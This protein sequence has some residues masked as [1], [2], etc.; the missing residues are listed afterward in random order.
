MLLVAILILVFSKQ[1]VFYSQLRPG[2]HGNLFR[3]YKLCSMTSEENTEERTVTGI[4]KILRKTSIDEL[5]QLI[6]ILRGEMS[7][8][9]P[10]P[11]LPEYLALYSDKHARRH[12]VKPGLTGLAQ[13][14]GR[15]HS[16]W[17]KRL[18]LDVQYVEQM[19]FILDLKIIGKTIFNIT[20]SQG[21]EFEM[22]KF[23]GYNEATTR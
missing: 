19:S 8:V 18:D 20:K 13:I 12:L 7:L 5:P 9:G 16:S 23:N 4:G 14:N 10:R 6:N 2:L 15:N 22:P 17:Q 3:L 11:L 1:K 21:Q